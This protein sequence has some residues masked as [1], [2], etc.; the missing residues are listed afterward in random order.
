MATFA[1]QIERTQKRED[2]TRNVRI[3]V[4]HNR[5]VMKIS[6]HIYVKDSDLT[7]GKKGVLIKNQMVLSQVNQILDEYRRKANDLGVDCLSLSVK[8]VIAAITSKETRSDIIDFI[9][10]SRVYIEAHKKSQPASMKVYMNAINSMEKYLSYISGAT[11]KQLNILDI[12]Y[13]FLTNYVTWMDGRRK[14]DSNPFI[15]SCFHSYLIGLRPHIK[16]PFILLKKYL[17]I[18]GEPFIF[19][20]LKT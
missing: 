8:E 16:E 7:I 2:G 9:S 1:Y 18:N 4:I 20:R 12:N 14:R 13:Q 15:Y 19:V 10:F 17:R 3:R 11:A 6:T 5:V